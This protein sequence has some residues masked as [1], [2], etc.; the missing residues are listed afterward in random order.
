MDKVSVIHK[1]K[2]QPAAFKCGDIVRREDDAPAVSVR[3]LQPGDA[4]TEIATGLPVTVTANYPQA[5]RLHT[6]LGVFDYP[7]AMDKL[8]WNGKR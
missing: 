2:G 4:V 1:S 6:W 8:S 5:M 7:S 3:Q